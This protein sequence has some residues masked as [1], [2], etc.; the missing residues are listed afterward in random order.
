ME[1]QSSYVLTKQPQ[2]PPKTSLQHSLLLTVPTSLGQ[3]LFLL[4]EALVNRTGQ[5]RDGMLG[6]GIGEGLRSHENGTS[7]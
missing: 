4:N 3:M 1:T 7:S 6:L 2:E 5:K